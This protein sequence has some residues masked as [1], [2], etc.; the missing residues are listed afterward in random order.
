[1][2]ARIILQES[3]FKRNKSKNVQNF[4]VQVVVNW[5]QCEFPVWIIIIIYLFWEY[6]FVRF[7]K[8]FLKF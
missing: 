6:L 8:D 2:K 3:F 7:F 4:G 5:I 1:M